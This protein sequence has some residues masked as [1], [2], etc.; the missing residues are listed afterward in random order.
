M[1]DGFLFVLTLVTA[2][3]CGVVGGVFFTFSTFVMKALGRLPAAQGAAAMQSINVVA[4]N[5]W[6]M[7]V[8]FGSGLACLGLVVASLVEWGEPFAVYLLAGGLVY[9]AGIVVLTG[10]YH[11]PR[12]DALAAVD[13]DSA[14]AERVWSRYLTEWTAANH[15]RT[16]AGVA[17]AALLTVALRVS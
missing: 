3:G 8:L 14:E 13:P 10:V 7:G 6:F 2:L 12:N 9:L 17:A 5:A 16:I 1:I 11:V 15:V 4:I